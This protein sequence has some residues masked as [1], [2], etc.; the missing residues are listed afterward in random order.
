MVDGRGDEAL[1]STF[2]FMDIAPLGRQ[3]EHEDSPEGYP[4]GSNAWWRRHDE[5]E[6]NPPDL[7]VDDETLAAADDKARAD[8]GLSG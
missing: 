5:Y 4:Q 6:T 1:G 2:S 3:E 8:A 7:P